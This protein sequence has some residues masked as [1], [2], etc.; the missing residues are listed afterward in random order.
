MARW[1]FWDWVGYACLGIAALGLAA[2]TAMKDQ[3]SLWAKLPDFFADPRWGYVPAILFAIGTFILAVEYVTPLFKRPPTPVAYQVKDQKKEEV[4]PKSR[5]F[6]DSTPD[7]LM[8][9]YREHTRIQADKLAEAYIGK[10]I[11]ISASVNNVSAMSGG[12]VTVTVKQTP[13]DLIFLKF[14]SEWAD[15]VAPM[16]REQNITVIGEIEEIR[17]D[18]L[19]LISCELVEGQ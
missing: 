1:G 3:P 16:R 8:S 18:S 12:G 15:R 2:G 17:F 11:K 9:F 19:I 14:G 4:L 10:W 13:M 6:V 7:H 5:V